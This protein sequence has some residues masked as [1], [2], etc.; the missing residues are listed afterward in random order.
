MRV[1][2]RKARYLKDH[3]MVLIAFSTLFHNLNE[4]D[5]NSIP[6]VTTFHCVITFANIS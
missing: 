3:H 2:L 4:Q 1:A 5:M 6:I